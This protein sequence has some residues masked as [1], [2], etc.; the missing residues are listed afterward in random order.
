MSSDRLETYT[1]ALQGLAADGRLRRLVPRSG[2]DFSSNDYLGLAQA[3]RIKRA[4]AAAME[5]GTPVGAGGSRLLRGNCEEHE[6]LE[7]AA[8]RFF[9]AESALFFGSGY[10]ANFAVLTTLPQRDDLLVLDALVHASTHEGARA[11]RAEMCQFIHNDPQSADD[12]ILAWRKD[13]GV[14]RPWIVVESLYSMDG[15]FAPLDDLVALAERH[16][17]F[18]LIDEAHATGVHGERG[19]GLAARYEGRESVV[20]VHTCGKALGAAG[21]LVTASRVLRD[22]LIN[23]C[24]PFIFATAPSPLM[25]VAVLEALAILQ[26]EPERQ[27]K[28]AQ[29][30]AF[31]HREIVTRFG[32]TWS[33]SQIVPYVVGDN[34]AA[35]ELALALQVQGFDVRGVRPPTVP[36]GTARLR[37]SLTLNVD[38]AAIVA[39]L[40]ALVDEIGAMRQWR[41]A[42]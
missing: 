5:V 3:P 30:V 42:S 27:Q 14:G 4:L 21:A 2:L 18:V 37:L 1:Q 36:A 38:E 23:R 29:L 10:L 39:L 9:G 35:M 31:A 20:I 11:G 28:L 25:A 17:G 16:D 6:R 15:D 22:T 7:E 40:D 8:A 33:P 19:R 34:A 41:S 12:A 32:E 24:R 26:D 13:G